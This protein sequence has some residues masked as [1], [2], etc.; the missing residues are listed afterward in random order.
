M[1]LWVKIAVIKHYVLRHL[2]PDFEVYVPIQCFASELLI[3]VKCSSRKTVTLGTF[4]DPKSAINLKQ[5]QILIGNSPASL[6]LT[7]HIFWQ[8]IHIS[9]FLNRPYTFWF[10]IYEQISQTDAQQSLIYLKRLLDK[11]VVRQC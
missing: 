8:T 2:H 3:Y 9:F 6:T 7:K 10:K 4:F 1:N 5:M 11:S